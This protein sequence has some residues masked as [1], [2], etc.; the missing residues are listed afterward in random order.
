[1][2]YNVKHNIPIST[3]LSQ[4]IKYINKKELSLAILTNKYRNKLQNCWLPITEYDGKR[5]IWK[6]KHDL[7]EQL[8]LWLLLALSS[9]S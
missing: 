2:Q 4:F 5:K 7:L 1:M 9:S 6:K 3:I 8:L